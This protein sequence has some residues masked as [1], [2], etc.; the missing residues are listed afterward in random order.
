MRNYFLLVI[1]F[2]SLVCVA[3][4]EEID[5]DGYNIFYYPNGQISSEGFMKNGK[6]DGYWKTYYVTGVLERKRYNNFIRI[7]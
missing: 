4:E 5:R 2:T 1:F 3:Q 7:S 6:P